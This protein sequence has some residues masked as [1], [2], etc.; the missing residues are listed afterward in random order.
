ML[1]VHAAL[2]LTVNNAY[3][4]L[5]G[6]SS[7][8]ALAILIGGNIGIMIIEGLVVYI[9]ALRLHLYEYFTKWYDGGAKPFKQ[10]VPE[11]IYNQLL[12]KK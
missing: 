5:G 8:G 10:I 3:T 11:M 9:Q 7:G 12:W 4:A 2:L 1:L 6:M